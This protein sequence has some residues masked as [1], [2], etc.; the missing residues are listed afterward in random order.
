MLKSFQPVGDA[1]KQQLSG[2]RRWHFMDLPV[3]GSVWD[4]ARQQKVNFWELIIFS[5][6]QIDNEKPFRV[7]SLHLKFKFFDNL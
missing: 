5:D 7:R 1:S 3:K 2:V 6:L 4:Q